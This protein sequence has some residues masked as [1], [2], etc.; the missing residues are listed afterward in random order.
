MS[1]PLASIGEND[2][3][4]LIGIC[5]S[6][7]EIQDFRH[8][9]ARRSI[10]YAAMVV[11]FWLRDATESA[12]W[13]TRTSIDTALTGGGPW[14]GTWSV[15]AAGGIRSYQFDVSPPDAEI[16]TLNEC[17]RL[18]GMACEDDPVGTTQTH[19][20]PNTVGKVAI[21]TTDWGAQYSRYSHLP[22]FNCDSLYGLPIAWPN[23]ASTGEQPTPP[24]KMVILG[25]NVG[26]LDEEITLTHCEA[27]TP[28]VYPAGWLDM[29]CEQRKI[30]SRATAHPHPHSG[31]HV[32]FL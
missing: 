19:P 27:L 10:R 32:V 26:L 9:A 23:C 5:T 18:V 7:A 1:H 17:Y 13:T 30:A 3:L 14:A 12:L 21:I 29:S 25:G 28:R 22:V 16:R 11:P 4:L 15:Y 6:W 24:E 2:I 31:A 8:T 20:I